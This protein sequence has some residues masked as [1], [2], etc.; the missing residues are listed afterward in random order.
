MRERMQQLEA[1]D[2]E[3][4]RVEALLRRAQQENAQLQAQLRDGGNNT[5]NLDM[6]RASMPPQHA[7]VGV[8]QRAPDVKR[9]PSNRTSNSARGENPDKLANSLNFTPGYDP[10]QHQLHDPLAN[11]ASFGTAGVSGTRQVAGHNLASALS[12]L[13]EE[14][15]AA[16]S[17]SLRST[18]SSG[19]SRPSGGYGE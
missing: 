19:P 12:R 8:V 11:T 13:E 5:G 3:R 7:R 17:S 9:R 18:G 1:S 10:R 6:P 2:M 15:F 4:V 16:V 14:Q